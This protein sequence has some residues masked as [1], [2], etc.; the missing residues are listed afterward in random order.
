MTETPKTDALD[1][2]IDA[3]PTLIG[4][5]VDASMRPAVRTD[6]ATSLKIA[7]KVGPVPKEAAATFR[8]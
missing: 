5:V 4:V 8:P 2:V 1:T 3:A 6:L 7:S